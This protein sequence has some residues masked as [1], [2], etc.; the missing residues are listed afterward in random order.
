ME[1]I[2]FQVENEIVEF[3]VL[4]QT[5]INGKNYLLVTDSDDDDATAYILKDQ[6]LESDAESVYDMV[7][8]DDELDAVSKIFE[9][10]MEDIDI[11]R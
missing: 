7:E 4:E 8:D 10:L 6:S 2:K 1:K 9:E 3:F 5:R 11:E